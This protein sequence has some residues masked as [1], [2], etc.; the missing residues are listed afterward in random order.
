MTTAERISLTL[1]PAPLDVP[2]LAQPLGA[3]QQFLARIPRSLEA[4]A[5]APESE[6]GDSACAGGWVEA[7]GGVRRCP[8]CAAQSRTRRL[9]DQYARAG[10]EGTLYQVSWGEVHLEHPSW[11]LARALGRNIRDVVR[12]GINVAM[13]GEKGRGKTQAGV[14]LAKDA[15]DA[16]YSALVVD[17]AD[18]VDDVQ[19][20]YTRRVKTQA[21]H[22]ATLTTPDLLVLDDV[23]AAATSAGDLERKLFTRVIGQRYNHRRATVVTAN[24]SRSELQDAMGERAFDRIEHACQWIVFNGPSYR[25]EVERRR[26]SATLERLQREAGL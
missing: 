15:I 24:L 14:L 25:A 8:R 17:W 20:D 9:A 11:R 22:V 26:V 6:C 18:W 5:P 1:N 16:E 21:E 2:D 19:S 4:A 13:V 12:E 23:G 10:V 3:A 7:E